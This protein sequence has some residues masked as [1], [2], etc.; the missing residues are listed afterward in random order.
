TT[1]ATLIIERGGKI[2]ADG[3]PTQPIVFTS[4][5]GNQGGPTGRGPGDWGGIII[6]GR[7]GINT[8]SGAD[9]AEIEGFGA[10]QGPIY[11]G[12]PV[13][14]DDSSGVLRYVRIEF[15]GVNITG[16]SGN[17]INGLT[18]GGVGSK[19]V[20]EH[21]QV[22][23]CGDDSFE[24]FGGNVNCKWLISY[25][26]VDDDWDTDNG[27]RG[28]VQFGLSVRDTVYHDQSTSN[29]FES[30][31]NNNVPANYNTPRTK[32]LF[33]NMT[34]IG[35]YINTGLSL[36]PDWS[37][38]GGHLRRRT[39]TCTYNSIIMG[40][41][42][43]LRFDECGVINAAN[44]DTMQHRSDV[45]AGNVKLTDTASNSGCASF[46]AH[47]WLLTPA[48][49]NTVYSTASSV[50]L[51]DPFNVYPN[52]PEGPVVNNWMPLPGSPVLTGAN[53]TYPNLAAGF[54]V[55]TFRGA[56]GTDNWTA[57]WAVFNPRLY[58][59]GIQQ[60]SLQVPAKF[61]LEQN[62][63]NPF[64]PVTN[65]KFS[66]PRSGFV[67]INV[68]NSIG[69]EV[70]TLVNQDMTVGTYKADFD[71]MNLSSGVYFYRITVKG[72]QGLE[73]TESKKMMLV[74]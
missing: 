73:W 11:G 20:I 72:S 43:G 4:R 21:V 19:T 6:L 54:D 49:N 28:R 74:K 69:E 63:P 33:C 52:G 12:Q 65:I 61:S 24:F 64:N 15:P 57:N 48:F 39:L 66:L 67:T 10:G 8:S 55:V 35:P 62:Y 3:T 45:F 16:T 37:S 58:V 9:S 17:E 18:M 70:S 13:V 30:D 27:Y 23:Y 36:H 53:F 56:F 34:V 38:R 7:S 50:Q 47:T 68:Y 1:K 22:S 25:K 41:R 60:I 44:G 2:I 40:W 5:K 46:N 51:T 31:N 29:G 59:I 32:P 71:A 42:V 14:N 26:P